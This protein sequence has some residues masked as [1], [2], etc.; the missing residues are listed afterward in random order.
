MMTLPEILDLIAFWYGEAAQ[1]GTHTGREML[2]ISFYM[3]GGDT[4]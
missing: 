1:N 4:Q 3:L 2:L